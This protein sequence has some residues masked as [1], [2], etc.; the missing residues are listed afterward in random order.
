ME[1]NNSKKK[2]IAVLG[3]GV[4]ALS[5]VFELTDFPGWED[6]YDITVYTPGWR[7]GGKTASSRGV[8][9]RVQERG[10]HILQGWYWNMFRLVRRSYDERKEKNIIPGQNFQNWYDAV[11]KD[12]TTLLTT[13]NNK[14]EWDA[15]PFIFPED[16]LVPGDAGNIGF[17]VMTVR[18]IG[19]IL[20]L[21]FGSP[22]K[23]RKGPL[24]FIPNFLF[25]LVMKN[26]PINQTDPGPIPDPVYTNDPIENAKLCEADMSQRVS[27]R[28]NMSLAIH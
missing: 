24:A 28:S 26:Y 1:A 21:F 5:S 16:D 9:N 7:A 27:D 6:L 19:V 3:S 8:N 2:K 11:V 10:I 17:K 18:V 4:G 14:D 15:W 25:G 23:T 12:D 13:K 20:Q 22:Y